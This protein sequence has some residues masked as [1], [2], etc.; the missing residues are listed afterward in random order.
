M[1][2]LWLL[3]VV[4]GLLSGA[5]YGA[6]FHIDPASGSAGNDGSAASPWASLQEVL[7]GGLVE[8]QEWESLPYAEGRALV[9]KNPGAPVKAGDTI[10]L[11]E[12]DYGTLTIQAFYNS[13][14]ITVAVPEGE[15]A[16][17]A[18]VLVRASSHWALEGF[19]VSNLYAAG[20]LPWAFVEVRRD[21]HW[22]PVH[23]VRVENALL[24]SEVDTWDWTAADWNSKTSHGIYAQ[25]ERVAILGNVLKNVGAGIQ[26]EA[27]Y[28][29]VAGNLVENFAGDGLR[30]L[31]DYTVFEDNVVKNAYSVNSNHDDGFQSWSLS[32]QGVVGQGAVTGIVL[33]RNVFIGFEDPDQPHRSVMQG[34]GCFDGMYVDWVVE[35]NVIV[36]D[37]WHGITLRGTENCR[38][39]NNT[40]VGL[41][42]QSNRNPWILLGE[43]N[44]GVVSMDNV[45]R[46]N[47][48]HAINTEGQAGV[49]AD[50]NITVGRDPD[51]FFVDYAGWDMRLRAGSVAIDAG[52]DLDAPVADI[53]GMPRDS[54]PDV[55][56]YEFVQGD[57]EGGG[58]GEGED[59]AEGEGEGEDGV[60]GE[61]EG[62]GTV[63]GEDEG[64]GGAE[65]EGEGDTDISGEGLG[66]GNSPV[67]C[68][69]P[70][71]A[72]PQSHALP[73]DL[74]LLAML[75]AALVV[76]GRRRRRTE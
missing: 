6:E 64:E 75:G 24:F 10:W 26:M 71:H 54:T 69:A 74:T 76:A 20:A 19:V 18:S 22:G 30:G 41:D 45:V 73:G 1:R 39:V 17:F 34:I 35:N 66:D 13:D 70:V 60:E 16:R 44:G 42:W 38:V 32:A 23:D 72:L 11:H 3:T 57:V 33:R 61:G 25:G 37:H 56:A 47:L 28:S 58:E 62:E 29:L 31:G 59:G 40:V 36:I 49:V 7:D 27:S 50:H 15:E 5:A 51:A 53:D 21:T 55:G 48:A 9:P 63:E 65:G 8:S 52:T 43:H 46:N 4:L 67:G 12:G 14:F 2:K 68:A